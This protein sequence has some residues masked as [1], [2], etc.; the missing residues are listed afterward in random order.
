MNASAA[1]TILGGLGLFLLG[2]ITLRKGLKGV[3]G[4]AAPPSAAAQTAVVERRELT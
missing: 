1:I 4:D 2:P 3:A